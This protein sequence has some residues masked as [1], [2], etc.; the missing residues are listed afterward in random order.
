[1]YNFY[2]AGNVNYGQGWIQ[3]LWG[4]QLNQ[5]EGPS[6]RERVQNYKYKIMYENE[7]LFTMREQIK[8][9][10]VLSSEIFLGYLLDA[11]T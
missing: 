9:N 1:M 2:L 5:F 7:I 3:V 4:P 8:T 10:Q 6:L 11:L